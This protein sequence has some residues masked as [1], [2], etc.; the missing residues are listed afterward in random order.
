VTTYDVVKSEY[1][2]YCASAKDE[3]QTTLKPKKKK[4][5]ESDDD[6]D[7][8]GAVRKSKPRSKAKTKC[9]L[10]GVKWFRIVLGRRP[11][12]NRS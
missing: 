1:D 4:G 2:N 7:S 8:S 5:A 6:S 11:L 10:F 9:A 3:S 12:C